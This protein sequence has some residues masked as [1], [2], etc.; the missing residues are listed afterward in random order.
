VLDSS[1]F[2]GTL[3][4]S[5]YTGT[6][7]YMPTTV[8]A[9][10]NAILHARQSHVPAVVYVDGLPKSRLRWF[11]AELRRLGIRTDKTVGVRK[12]EA[13]AL[14]RLADACCGFARAALWGKQPDMTALFE[15]GKA[16]GHVVQV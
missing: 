8:V 2:R 1:L 13:D 16:T 7:S 12:E 9:T 4:F 3:Y 6:S 15:R 11:G 5:L 10:A 14:M